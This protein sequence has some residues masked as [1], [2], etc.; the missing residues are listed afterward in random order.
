MA[1]CNFARGTKAKYTTLTSID[2]DTIY[3]ITDTGEILI[4]GVNYGSS[5]TILAL[6]DEAF[7]E[8]DYNKT[9]GVLT[10]T[11]EDGTEATVTL[12]VLT[13]K[14][15]DTAESGY[16]ASYQLQ[17]Q[18]GTA[19]GATINIPKDLVVSDGEVKTVTT[20]DTPYTGAVVGDKYIDLTIA[21]TDNK[22]IYVPVNDLVDIY[23]AGNGISVSNNTIAVKLDSSGESFLTVGSSGLKLSGVQS[24]INTAAATATTKIASKTTGHVTVSSASNSD[25]STTYTIAEDD[26][27]SAASLTSEISRAEAAEDTI[28]A[29]VGLNADGSHKTTTGNYTSKATTIA[30]E[31]S[32]LD[33]QVK[34]NA[35]AIAAVKADE[36]YVKNVTVNGVE[37]TIANN[38]ATVTID[39]GDI[40]LDGYTAAT[41]SSTI[42]A[43]DTVNDALGKLAY[44]LT[45]QEL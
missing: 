38:T 12:P 39:G 17:N 22:H 45:W 13:I 27:A 1:Y 26:I 33:T 32:A 34:T 15:L 5:D 29:S 37:A 28:E 19:I 9:T 18:D 4:N 43:T 41:S 2:A 44:A 40:K 23:K 14:K 21:N 36:T 35:D 24:A 31:I 7:K 30:G 16:S 42:T 10:F 8:V 20:A 11:K 25:G 3:F 6:I